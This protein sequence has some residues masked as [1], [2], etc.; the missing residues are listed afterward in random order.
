MLFS[1]DSSLP[2][3]FGLIGLILGVWV[4]LEPA[5]RP[6]VEAERGGLAAALAL[7]VGVP[8]LV[9]L[10]RF[11][12]APGGCAAV[13]AG[14]LVAGV[15]FG[16]G[17][18]PLEVAIGLA[19][20]NALFL[21]ADAVVRPLVARWRERA[22]MSALAA[23]RRR[24][25]EGNPTDAA[26]A[27]LAARLLEHG[28]EVVRVV[29]A[30][31]LS[32][33]APEDALGRIEQAARAGGPA[34]REAANVA[35]A[36]LA[37]RAAEPALGLAATLAADADERVAVPAARRLASL[38][39]GRARALELLSA[40]TPAVA[41]ALGGGLLL[42]PERDG[43]EQAVRQLV[44]VAADPGAREELR[45]RA[46]DLLTEP[47]PEVERARL[48]TDPEVEPAP[49]LPPA[50]LAIARE[51]VRARLSDEAVTPELL[52]LAAAHGE[53]EDAPRAATWIGD[54][55]FPRTLASLEAV[56]G[57]VARHET[58]G[59]A[60]EPTHAALTRGKTRIREVHPE[61]DN[62]LADRVVARIDGLLELLEAEPTTA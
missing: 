43:N 25:G 38:P 58:L 1:R 34:A 59:A 29:A 30:E 50:L 62:M 28:S 51:A 56:A 20:P 54:P 24:S 9:N 22:A 19:A 8:A 33:A 2:L 3:L 52:W 44:R 45:S 41:L 47:T 5:L 35:L 4:V 36:L 60:R 17:R 39:S 32:R 53:P 12:R 40:A 48:Q 42:E 49:P 46:V 37:A 14:F 15:L 13:P 6:L 26:G 61:D 10:A 11:Q 31:T 18:P 55:D 57:I 21:L 7:L 16:V 23:A 27:E